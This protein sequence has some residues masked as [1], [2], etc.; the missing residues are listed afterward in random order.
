MAL[1]LTGQIGE[2]GAVYRALHF[3]GDYIEALEVWDRWL[4]PLITIDVGGKCGFIDPDEK[5]QRLRPAAH[6]GPVRRGG[7]GLALG[8]RRDACGSTSARS[9]P[10]WRRPP[11][12]G[13]VHR[14]VTSPAGRCSGPSWAGT[15]AAGS[16]TS[17]RRRRSCAAGTSRRWV[18]FNVVPSSR[19]VFAQACAE[20]LVGDLFAAGCTWFPPSTGSN[21][22]DQHGRH[23]RDRGLS[24]SHARNFPG[25]TAA[26]TRCMYLAS[27]STVAASAVRQ[28]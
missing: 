1:W 22:A 24:S 4:F 26:R 6:H 17:G 13:N 19:E 23:V 10:R 2:G 3:A 25:R 7:L 27:A 28:V 21:Q 15:A 20:G 11:T 16:R 18:K 9:N 14:S 5:T 8:G 12:L